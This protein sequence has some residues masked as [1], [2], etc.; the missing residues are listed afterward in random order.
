MPLAG[1]D[2]QPH[3]GTAGGPAG[4]LVVVIEVDSRVRTTPSAQRLLRG[5]D[6]LALVAARADIAGDASVTADGDRGPDRRG[7]GGTQ[8][9]N[10]ANASGVPSSSHAAAE[11]KTSRIGKPAPR[12]QRGKIRKRGL[13]ALRSWGKA[14]LGRVWIDPRDRR[15]AARDLAHR[16]L[17]LRNIADIETIADQDHVGMIVRPRPKVAHE[18]IE[19]RADARAAAPG[20]AGIGDRPV[21][22]QVARNFAQ[23]RAKDECACAPRASQERRA[24]CSAAG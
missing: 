14:R 17:E 15:A 7:L 22:P 23:R 13:H 11:T 20:L 12:G 1:A 24:T 18:G 6:D 2:Q 9:A 21:S 19:A 3:H 4:K 5:F 10:V 8:F 16:V